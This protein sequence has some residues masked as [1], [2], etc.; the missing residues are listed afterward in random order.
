MKKLFV[1]GPLDG[2]EHEAKSDIMIV[3]YHNPA[4]VA[5]THDSPRLRFDAVRF[6][7]ILLSEDLSVEVKPFLEAVYAPLDGQ[8]VYQGDLTIEPT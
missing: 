8:M 7:T 1:G 5:V 3:P 2:Q 6:R 4:F